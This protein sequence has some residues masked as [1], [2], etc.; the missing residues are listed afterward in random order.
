MSRLT[1]FSFT[2]GRTV[3]ALLLLSTG[4]V[5]AQ[6]VQVSHAWARAMLPGQ[7]ASAAYMR[8]TAKTATRLVDIS[9]PLAGVAEVHDMK[10]EGDVMKM[11]LIENL[12]LPAGKTVELKKGGAHLMLMDLNKPLAAGTQLPLTLHFKDAKGVASRMDI[13][14]PV[15]TSAPRQ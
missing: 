8:L 10:M 6:T 9:S 3:A 5:F 4:S 11:R 1:V 15:R 14:V 7:Q 12:E 2:T 13:S